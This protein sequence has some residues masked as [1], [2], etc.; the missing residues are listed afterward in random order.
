MRPRKTANSRLVSTR[1]DVRNGEGSADS[2]SAAAGPS[3]MAKSPHDSANGS[4]FQEHHRLGRPS[5][6]GAHRNR[7]GRFSSKRNPLAP[8]PQCQGMAHQVAHHR[9]PRGGIRLQTADL[10]LMTPLISAIPSASIGAPPRAPGKSPPLG[11]T[12]VVVRGAA[13]SIVP[14]AGFSSAPAGLA[15]LAG[16]PWLQH[17]GEP[18]QSSNRAIADPPTCGRLRMPRAW[19]PP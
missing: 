5:S 1:S 9:S 12:R 7:V 3:T 8:L 18:S 6:G 16:D 10:M 17:G 2:R 15:Y 19:C 13:R 14:I 4:V 11:G